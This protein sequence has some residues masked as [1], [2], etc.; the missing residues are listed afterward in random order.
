MRVPLLLGRNFSESDDEKAPP[1]AIVN[2]T[3]ANRFW[4]NENAIGKRFSLKS[5]SGPFI[6][7]V[8][9]AHDGQYLFLSPDSSPYFYVPFAQNP[10]SFASLQLRSFGTAGIADPGGAERDRQAGSRSAGYEHRHNGPDR[11]WPCRNVH[12]SPGGF[13]GRNHGGPGFGACGGGCLWRGFVFGDPAHPRNWNSHGSWRGETRHSEAGFVARI[14]AGDR[15]HSGRRGSGAGTDSRDAQVVDGH[16]RCRP[17]DLRGRRGHAV[18][19]DLA[20]V[21]HPRPPRRQE[22]IPWWR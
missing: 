3:M 2:Q 15:R 7:V 17:G 21:L 16:Q 14:A 6:E 8:G 22:W 18:G 10:S 20:R 1:V 13:T 4:P 19:R 11:A 5:A 12:F 9:V